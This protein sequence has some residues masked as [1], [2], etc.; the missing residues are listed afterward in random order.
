M[1]LAATMRLTIPSSTRLNPSR[2]ASSL[3]YMGYVMS[4]QTRVLEAL[5]WLP[6]RVDIAFTF[7]LPAVDPYIWQDTFISGW[8][9]GGELDAILSIKVLDKS[10]IF[11]IKASLEAELNTPAIGGKV[12]G[13]F[14]MTK[15]NL[16]R[17]T[18]TTVTVNWS[19]GGSIKDPRED[20]TIN[21]LKKAAAA[22]PELVAIT[23]QRTFAILT[24]YTALA[25][26]Q[27]KQRNF[28]PL[29]YENAGIYTSALL[30][31][32]MDYKALWKQ[33]SNAT[34]ELE[35]NRATIDMAEPDED[36]AALAKTE[37]T[38]SKT[39]GSPTTKQLSVFA[40]SFAG[41]IDARNVCRFEMAKIVKE[42]DE[43][44]KDPSLAIDPHRDARFL[45][46]LIFKLLLPVSCRFDAGAFC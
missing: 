19:G 24:K 22:F 28:T 15:N 29:D 14:E 7:Y 13:A 34:Y 25:D 43:V 27:K 37:E 23:P 40:P 1:I 18:E 36:L 20:W 38:S 8:E 5:G 46:P 16:S 11:E 33:I 3:K 12:E 21:S 9:E 42:V 44:A 4:F 2:K 31:S 6:Y 32:Y 39:E 10:K 30:D 45:H 41:L 35:A 26:F 17:D